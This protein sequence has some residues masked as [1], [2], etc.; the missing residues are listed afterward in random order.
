[1]FSNLMQEINDGI[2][3]LLYNKFYNVKD[4]ELVQG[5]ITDKISMEDINLINNNL[6]KSIGNL[7][8]VYLES[9]RDNG[10]WRRYYIVTKS[11]IRYG[12]SLVTELNR[13]NHEIT[14]VNVRTDENYAV[15][16]STEI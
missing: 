3:K 11:N 12:I 14:C 5:D 2:N 9:L 10:K 8:H 4:C 7:E 1:M 15:V 6:G 16:A 13:N